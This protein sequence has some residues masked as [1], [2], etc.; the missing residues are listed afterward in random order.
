MGSDGKPLSGP[1]LEGGVRW[2]QLEEGAPLLGHA[3]GEP[4]LL[5]R[6]GQELFATGA[7]CTHYGGPLAEGLVVDET[8]RCP[9]H[10]ACFSLRTGEAL[11]APALNPLPCYDVD[12]GQ[13]LVRVLRKRAGGPAA[14]V[15]ARTPSSVVIVGAG[16]AGAA[17][18]ETLRREGF[19]GPVT[20]V[21]DEPPGPVDRPNLSKDYLAGSAPEEWIPLRG[22]EFYAE[23]AIDLVLGD[24]AVR[25]DTAAHRVFLRSGRELVY[26]ALVL[27]TGAEPRRLA[28]PGAERG[29]VFTL[30]TLADSRAIIAAAAGARRAVVVGASFIGLEVA[31]SLRKRGLE[32]EVV[33]Q[34]PLPLARVLGDE[35]AR[36]IRAVHER[37]GVRFHLGTSVARIEPGAVELPGGER[38]AA[39]LVVAGIG[40]TPRTELAQAAGLTIDNGI[41]VDAGLRASAPDVYAAGDVANVTDSRTGQGTRIEHFV[42]AERQGQAAAR[43]LLGVG[44]PYRDVPFFWS[45]HHDVT[46]SYVGHGAGYDRIETRGDL[47]RQDYAAFYLRGARVLATLTIG[48]DQLSL[49]VEA[50]LA[51]DDHPTLLALLARPERN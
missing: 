23:Q 11:A 19:G 41:R 38:L 50:A 3:F 27:A 24:P 14:R 39:D 8:V 16:P 18:A 37:N 22:P 26:G 43:S 49:R 45:Q 21:G 46:L 13:D 4:V 2:D 35:V 33:G 9:W 40:V 10:H 6:R 7:T 31:A 12:R 51:T 20:L 47:D 42:V 32:V 1:D 44:G 30:R 29:P 34:E 15:P 25:L 5:V 28:V 48:R 17:C 36:F